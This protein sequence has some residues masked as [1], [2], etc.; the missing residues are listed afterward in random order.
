M[1]QGIYNYSP[2]L[3]Y[4]L[5]NCGDLF[6]NLAEKEDNCS[7]YYS[8]QLYVSNSINGINLSIFIN[9]YDNQEL[10]VDYSI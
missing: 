7:F 6:I 2:V 3:E 8:K 10:N 1:K 9:D 5:E 4:S